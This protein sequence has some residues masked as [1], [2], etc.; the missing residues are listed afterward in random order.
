[1][2]KKLKRVGQPTFRLTPAG[3]VVWSFHKTVYPVGTHYGTCKMFSHRNS[4][5]VNHKRL[6]CK[7]RDIVVW[8]A[9]PQPGFYVVNTRCDECT[10]CTIHQSHHGLLSDMFSIPAERK[11]VKR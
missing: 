7:G 9:M 1:M 10:R 5:D 4:H 3:T 8:S 2:D 11:G 6:Y